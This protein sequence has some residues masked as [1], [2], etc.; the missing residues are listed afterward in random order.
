MSVEIDRL[1]LSDEEEDIKKIAARIQRSKGTPYEPVLNSVKEKDGHLL[2][3]DPSE[4]RIVRAWR[5][6]RA[7]VSPDEKRAYGEI[8]VYISRWRPNFEDLPEESHLR[9]WTTG[10]QVEDSEGKVIMRGGEESPPANP[11]PRKRER[12]EGDDDDDDDGQSADDDLGWDPDD[13]TGWDS[14]G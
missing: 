11:P 12:A 8:R 2:V 14:D 7:N 10:W 9:D 5:L 1:E 3:E 4:Q 6:L 13:A